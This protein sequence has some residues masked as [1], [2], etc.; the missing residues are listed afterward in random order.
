VG[1]LSKHHTVGEAG[2]AVLVNDQWHGQGIGTELL[3]R[4]IEI[5]R[6]EKLTILSGKILKDNQVMQ[7]MCRKLGFKVVPD[8]DGNMLNASY[9]Y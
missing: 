5:G 3:R 2:F 4:L 7:N 6:A 9:T 1:R 8:A